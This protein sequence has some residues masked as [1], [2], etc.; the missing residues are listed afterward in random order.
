MLEYIY[1]NTIER[2]LFEKNSRDILVI[3]EKYNISSL[4]E[5]CEQFISESISIKGFTSLVIFADTYSCEIIMT[6]SY[7]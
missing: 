2:T 3:A 4:K 1:M 6:V 5:E 7:F